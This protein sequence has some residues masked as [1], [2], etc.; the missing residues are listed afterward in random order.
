MIELA[1]T[2]SHGV[3]VMVQDA[4]STEQYCG[5]VTGKRASRKGKVRNR[6]MPRI[7]PLSSALNQALLSRQASVVQIA[8]LSRR[9]TSGGKSYDTRDIAWSQR[10]P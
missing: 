7:S 5:S 1:V 3:L 6:F 4:K 10:S 2:S 9:A 8:M